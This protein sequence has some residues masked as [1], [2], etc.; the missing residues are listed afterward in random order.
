MHRDTVHKHIRIRYRQTLQRKIRRRQ[1]TVRQHIPEQ[2]AQ[3]LE[4]FV[5]VLVHSQFRRRLIVEVL[6]TPRIEVLLRQRRGLL[7]R[8]QVR[9]NAAL[10]QLRLQLRKM[11]APFVLSLV[12]GHSGFILRGRLRGRV[13][14]GTQ[15]LQLLFELL[16]LVVQ[17]R[18]LTQGHRVLFLKAL[19]RVCQLLLRRRHLGLNFLHVLR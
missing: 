19:P 9:H 4:Q 11:G 16:D 2:T 6:L 12:Q 3:L 15:I 8:P 5:V 18:K 13:T 7:Q 17:G 10:F 1:Q 14:L